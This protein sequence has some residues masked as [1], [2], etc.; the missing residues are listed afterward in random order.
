MVD[1]NSGSI[2]NCLGC[3]EICNDDDCQI[4][5]YT[6]FGQLIIISCKPNYY[7]KNG[8]CLQCDQ[9][10]SI[11]S[12]NVCL[13]CLSN[14]YFNCIL[15]QCLMNTKLKQ[16]CGYNCLKCIYK[17]NQNRCLK[18][19]NNYKISDD[20][21]NCESFEIPNCLTEYNKQGIRS[22]IPY[23]FDPLTEIITEQFLQSLFNQQ[24][25][26]VKQKILLIVFIVLY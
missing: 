23:L 2:N 26:Y 8:E 7:F 6:N 11:C 20:G 12:N 10:C 13:Q 25:N 19:I 1:L 22:T 17:V 14:Y 16:Q 21:Y 18:C 24:L 4:Y 5:K 15:Q 9:F 3:Q